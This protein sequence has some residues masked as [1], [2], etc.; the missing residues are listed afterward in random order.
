ML[1][2]LA[3]AQATLTKCNLTKWG[4]TNQRQAFNGIA[5]CTDTSE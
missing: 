1:H 5:D 2:V 4:G 3:H